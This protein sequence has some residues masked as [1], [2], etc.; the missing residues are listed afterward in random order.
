MPK[1]ATPAD[2]IAQLEEPRRSA[3]KAIHAMITRALPKL[4]PSIQFGMIGYGTYDCRYA[5]GRTAP[6]PVIAL[7]SQK[8]HIAVYGSGAELDKQAKAVLPKADFGKGCVRFNK[9]DDVDL[10]ALEKIVKAAAQAK[11][12]SARAASAK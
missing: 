3:I 5:G 7:A 9:F 12:K 4:E 10:E 1:P 6:A 2:Y 11:L 8:S